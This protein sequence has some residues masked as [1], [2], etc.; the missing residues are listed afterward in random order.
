M[1]PKPKKNE[2]SKKTEQKKKE[3]VIEDKTF[4]I[5]NKKGG[6]Q[7]KFIKM[8]QTQVQHGNQSARKK[9][10]LE[11]QEKLNKKDQKKKQ[12]EELNAL[13]KPV[14]QKVGHG[15]DPKSVLCSFYKQGQC[16]KGDKCKFSHDLN[17]GR[18]TEKRSVYEDTRAAE[19]TMDNWDEAKLEDVVNKKHGETNKSMPKTAIICKYFLE[20]LE[21]SKY[22]WFW[23]CPNG[24]N[25]HYRHALPPGFVLKKDKKKAEAKDEISL[26]ELIEKER[27]A[28]S[29]TNLTK[30]TLETFL[31]WKEKKKKEKIA[32][33][34]AE[35]KKKKQ[36]FT[37]GRMLGISGREMFTFNPDLLQADDDEADD[38][39]YK[40]SD[41]EEEEEGDVQ[42]REINLDALAAEARE[43]DD[44]GTKA[45]EGRLK[46]QVE[47]NEEAC[48][49]GI[50]AA[51]PEK[52]ENDT[53]STTIDPLAATINGD[54]IAGDTPIDENL[55][56]GE[57]LDLVEEEL[58][59][60]ELDD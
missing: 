57:D 59:E 8:V 13:F 60:L 21:E 12:M 32:K 16:G 36:D 25:C 27:A 41:S 39:V 47:D 37:A 6:K 10:L 3:K 22:G 43:A 17:I 28:L 49:L 23:E 50:A 4:G 46:T 26:E 53:D 30:V 2:P 7:Q 15:V 33:A 31:Q 1:P 54:V 40:H 34:E 56:D 19:D 42:V 58:D 45:V 5:K 38:V 48:K 51:L 11:Q 55:F 18:K 9:E 24:K 52:T 20:A 29:S 44:S 35:Q 14:E